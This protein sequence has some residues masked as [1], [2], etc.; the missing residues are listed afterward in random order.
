MKTVA[1]TFL[2]EKSEPIKSP[3]WSPFLAI[4]QRHKK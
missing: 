4:S 1:G 3:F 2:G